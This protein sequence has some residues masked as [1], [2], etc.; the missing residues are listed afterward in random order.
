MCGGTEGRVG[1]SAAFLGQVW[2]SGPP[3]AWECLRVSRMAA[4]LA[5]PL[6]VR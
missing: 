5:K 4:C 2:R 3:Q 1:K 6:V